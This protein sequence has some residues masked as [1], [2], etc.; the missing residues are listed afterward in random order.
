MLHKRLR[1]D[2]DITTKVLRLTSVR[3]RNYVMSISKLVLIMFNRV[4]DTLV[5]LVSFYH[6]PKR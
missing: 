4:V 2:L 5:K 1:Y 6:L 3:Y